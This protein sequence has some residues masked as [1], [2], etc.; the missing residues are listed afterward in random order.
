MTNEVLTIKGME[1]AHCVKNVKNALSKLNLN[2]KD[3][4]I[5]SASIE[6]DEAITPRESIVKAIEDAGYEVK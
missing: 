1:C 4:Q 3:V 6:Y 2:I 5:G